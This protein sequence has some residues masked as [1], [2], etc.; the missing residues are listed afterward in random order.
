MCDASLN[1]ILPKQLR[2]GYGETAPEDFIKIFSDFQ[3]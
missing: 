3:I 1:V 2:E